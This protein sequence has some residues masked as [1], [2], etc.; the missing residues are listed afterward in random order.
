MLKNIVTNEMT[1]L[2]DTENHSKRTL[3]KLVGFQKNRIFK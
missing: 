1:L 3:D 2:T